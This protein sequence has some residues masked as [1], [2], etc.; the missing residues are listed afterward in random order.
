MILHARRYGG[1]LE[2]QGG[3]G[4]SAQAH[5]MMEGATGIAGG[6]RRRNVGATD[7]GRRGGAGGGGRE[8]P[9][10]EADRVGGAR[11]PLEEDLVPATV[12]RDAGV[13]QPGAERVAP[14]QLFNAICGG[15]HG[16]LSGEELDVAVSAD[17][18]TGAS[19]SG[20]RTAEPKT[21]KQ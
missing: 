6:G 17:A 14:R 18:L 13:A 1:R 10:H 20:S 19:V 4:S 8:P 7:D 21:L 11:G 9:L 3:A 15:C 5:L 12:G 16:S 2:Y